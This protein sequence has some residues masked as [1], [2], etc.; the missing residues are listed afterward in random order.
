MSNSFYVLVLAGGSGERF[1]PLSRKTAP[2]QLLRLLGDTSLLE[3]TMNRL[4]GLVSPENIVVLTNR[5]QEQ[6][7]RKVLSKHPKQNIVAEPAKRDTA[8]AIALGVGVIAAKNHAATMAVLPADHKIRDTEAFRS[9]LK[10]AA[11]AAERTGDLVTIGITPT[12]ACPGFGYIERGKAVP[13]QDLFEVERF[14]EKPNPDLAET[15]V[16]SGNFYWNAG[17]FIWTVNSILTELNRHASDL[18][19]FV[20]AVRT[21][22]NLNETLEQQFASLRK[23]S[24]DYAI[25]EKARRVLVKPANFDWDDLGDWSAVAKYLNPLP[26]RNAANCALTFDDAANN[27]VYSDQ[28]LHVALL[29]VSDL[30]I[31]QT[32]DAILVCNRHET[33]KIKRIVAGLPEELQ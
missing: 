15:F 27:I 6:A 32:K 23:I 3:D 22:K 21:S 17:M 9:D 30:V 18:A 20:G 12:W 11:Q 14:R 13:G 7:V 28:K 5:E 26:E 19:E 16:R 4:D 8:A 31:V 25:M 10:A 33:E 24:I 29:G 2:K 1:W